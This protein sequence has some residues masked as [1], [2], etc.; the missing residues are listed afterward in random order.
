[1]KD[2]VPELAFIVCVVPLN[3]TCIL[4][5][6]PYCCDA[7]AETEKFVPAWTDDG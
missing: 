6:E 5:I 4:D 7:E 3:V 1:V 2:T